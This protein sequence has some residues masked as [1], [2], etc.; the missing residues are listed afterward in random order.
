MKKLIRKGGRFKGL[1]VGLDLHL[2]FIQYAVFNGRGQEIQSGRI[3]SEASCLRVWVGRLRAKNRVQV[4][5]EACGSFL[6]VFD[7]LAEEL[8]RA[9]VHVAHPG[10]M[11][12][13]L[14][15]GEKSDQTDAWWLAY[16]LWDGR[17]PEAFV[18]EG[19]LRDLRVASRELRSVTDQRSDLI[20]RF[21]SHLAQAGLKAPASW[22]TSKTKRKTTRKVARQVEGE[23]GLAVRMLYSQIVRLIRE[24]SF[25][26]SRVKE[27]GEGFEILSKMQAEIPGMK[28]I[29]SGLVYGEL[30]DPR[31]F[32]SQK[33]YANA[34]GLTPSNRASAGRKEAGGM[35]RAGSRHARWGLTRA[36]LGCLRCK[37]GPGAHVGAWVRRRSRSTPKRKVI[38]AAARKLAE[39]VWRLCSW[40]EAF[41]LKKAFPGKT[42]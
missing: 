13:V 4:S 18:A 11:R 15:C 22:W 25:W 23:R 12:A 36:V 3:S 28:S 42:G 9:A 7:L 40:G 8:G 19:R 27:L 29:V 30:G 2:K 37:Q 1:T 31:R 16:L 32:R 14:R 10:N 6:W 34:T 41:D 24:V 21:R 38:V 33:A 5:L 39:G 35:T 17:L 20:R 26:R